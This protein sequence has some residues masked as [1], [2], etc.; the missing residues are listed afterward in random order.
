MNE[1]MKEK[2][3]RGWLQ[4]KHSQLFSSHLF[5]KF[6]SYFAIGDQTQSLSYMKH[7]LFCCTTS[8]ALISLFEHIFVELLLWPYSVLAV[9]AV[10]IRSGSLFQKTDNRQVKRLMPSSNEIFGR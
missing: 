3:R 4:I 7:A 5:L 10:K 6:F 9:A 8:P 2:E 1:S